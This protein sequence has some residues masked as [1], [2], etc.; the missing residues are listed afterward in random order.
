VDPLSAG[1]RR[2]PLAKD[3]EVTIGPFGLRP[4][5]SAQPDQ[6]EPMLARSRPTALFG[7]R[8]ELERL[9][10]VDLP[11]L[12]QVAFHPEAGRLRGQKGTALVTFPRCEDG[13]AV[14]VG[15]E[16][17]PRGGP[18]DGGRKLRGWLDER[19]LELSLRLPSH[20]PQNSDDTAQEGGREPQEDEQSLA[21]TGSHSWDFYSERELRS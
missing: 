16:L 3:V 14:D 2:V 18:G 15:H 12:E 4:Q 9:E 8:P 6:L 7:I 21:R 13:H 10:H 20:D 11:S 5:V 17:G 1:Q 19:E